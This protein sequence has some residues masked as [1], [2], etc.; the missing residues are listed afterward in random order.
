[1]NNNTLKNYIKLKQ[2]KYREESGQ[3]LIEGIHLAEECLKSR[4]YKK[5]IEKIFLRKDFNDDKLLQKIKG[6]E[7][8]IVSEIEFKKL[9]ETEN[10]QGII[11]L[12]KKAENIPP[13]NDRI[14]CALDGI[15]DPG[16]LG[17]IFRL[18]WWFGIDKVLI[19][20][21]SVEIYNSKVIRASQGAI[22]NLF[23]KENVD[24]RNEL[25]NLKDNNY[26][27]LL[28]DLKTENKIQNYKFEKDKKYVL[29]FGNEANGI[30][31]EIKNDSGFKKIKID[32]YSNCES[33]NVAVSA[34]IIFYELRKNI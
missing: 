30:S 5:N 16:N 27:I 18:C 12:V 6:I 10:S 4:Y 31:N 20:K 19:S 28:T 2:K 25:M 9:A 29:V 33:L 26:E 3:F 1:M 17:T 22:F 11:A 14:I 34:G 21:N 13:V 15:N 7:V 24:L 23:V 8:E 32:S